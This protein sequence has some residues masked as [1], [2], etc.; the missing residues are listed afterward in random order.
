MRKYWKG[1][2]HMTNEQTLDPN[3]KQ[4]GFV[5]EYSDRKLHRYIQELRNVITFQYECVYKNY[6]DESLIQTEEELI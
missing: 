3:F 5:Q 2:V 1:I 4:P 6:K